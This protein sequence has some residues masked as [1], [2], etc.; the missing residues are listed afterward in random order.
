MFRQHNEVHYGKIC[1]Q[2]SFIKCGKMCLRFKHRNLTDRRFNEIIVDVQ[3]QTDEK[4]AGDV[5]A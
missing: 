2:C 4:A 1:I 5:E 3:L